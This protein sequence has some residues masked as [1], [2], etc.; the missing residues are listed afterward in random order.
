MDDWWIVD[1]ILLQKVEFSMDVSVV[2]LATSE[3]EERWVKNR[4][5]KWHFFG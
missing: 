1:F 2:I 4:T 3:Y 5:L